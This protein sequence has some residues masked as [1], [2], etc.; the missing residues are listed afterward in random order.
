MIVSWKE[1]KRVS[2]QSLQERLQTVRELSTDEQGTYLYEVAKDEAT[3]EHYL[4][5]AYLHIDVAGSTEQSYHQ[6]LPLESDDVLGI[7]FG[8]TPYTYPEHW[9]RPFLRNGPDD[10]YVW[11][12]PSDNEIGASDEQE[13]LA[14]EIAGIL[15]EW[16]HGGRLDAASVKELLDAIDQ[17]LKRDEQ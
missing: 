13:R 8:E 5:Y 4:H 7:M 9:H 2:G 15:G 3:G 11:F 12:D 17:K 14:G 16:K 10:M 1:T 6:L